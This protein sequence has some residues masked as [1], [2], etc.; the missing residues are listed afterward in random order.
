MTKPDAILIAG[1]TASGKSQLA[2]ESARRVGGEIVNTDSM[3]IYDVLRAL[4]ARPSTE[5]EAV[6]SHHLYGFVSP[7]ESFSVAKWLKLATTIAD[8]IGA[9]GNVP[10]FVGG[11][12]LYFKALEN[13]LADVPVIPEEIRAPIRQALL[14][15]GSEALHRRLASV[16]AESAACLLP[17]DGQRVA[18]ALEV[19]E[20]AGKSLKSFQQDAK[21][22]AYL[23]RRC[24]DKILLMPERAKLH[25]RINLRTTW[26]MEHGAVGEVRNLLAVDLPPD[27][28][29]MQAIGVKPLDAYLSGR[30]SFEEALEKTRDATRQYAKRQSTWFRRQHGDEWRHIETASEALTHICG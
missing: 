7:L 15:D 23:N 9:R 29:V 30:S 1:P 5:D 25:K 12:G 19:F 11:T 6:V 17:S 2:L 16:D 22:I 20:A 10:V 14:Q 24:V 27:A 18:R 21:S 3:Q 13:G 28:T 4:T 8:E 26:M